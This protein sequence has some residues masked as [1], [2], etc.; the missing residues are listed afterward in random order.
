MI[1]DALESLW[2]QGIC[3]VQCPMDSPHKRSETIGLSMDRYVWSWEE[4]GVYGSRYIFGTLLKHNTFTNTK[5]VLCVGK[6]DVNKR[7]YV[8]TCYSECTSMPV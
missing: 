7:L 5:H 8:N 3:M 1:A 4:S 2:R 6:K